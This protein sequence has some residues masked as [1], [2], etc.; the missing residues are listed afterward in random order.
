M[1]GLSSLLPCLATDLSVLSRRLIRDGTWIPYYIV[2]AKLML[3]ALAPGYA[4]NY[5]I[6]SLLSLGS[7]SH[8]A[9][10]SSN[11]RMCDARA[12]APP[13]NPQEE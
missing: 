11:L 1:Y 7:H 2:I 4:R 5:F 12:L 10:S 9:I 6:A 8:L 13:E 3:G